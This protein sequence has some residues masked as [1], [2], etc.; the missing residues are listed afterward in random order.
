MTSK[1]SKTCKTTYSD[2]KVVVEV[3][4]SNDGS[5]GGLGGGAHGVSFHGGDG[6]NK[7]IYNLRYLKFFM[8]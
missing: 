8:I 3:S 2:N 6:L 5:L 7:K 1:T 4:L